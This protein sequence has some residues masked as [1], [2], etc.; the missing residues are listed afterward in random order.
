MEDEEILQ[1]L[2]NLQIDIQQVAKDMEELKRGIEK[3]E[4]FGM[5]RY[6]IPENTTNEKVF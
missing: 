6:T 3:N 1:H 2:H 4:L 5:D